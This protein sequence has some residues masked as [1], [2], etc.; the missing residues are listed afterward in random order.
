M[1][2]Y[3]VNITVEHA[4]KNSRLLAF[5]TFPISLKPLLVIPH[6]FVLFFLMIGASVC[7]FLGI[8]GVIIFGEYP[9]SLENYVV[10]VFRWSVR[11]QAYMLCLTDKYPPFSLKE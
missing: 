4:P 11:V 6:M 7:Y 5:I 3:P 9:K 1:E 2:K 8:I 10:G